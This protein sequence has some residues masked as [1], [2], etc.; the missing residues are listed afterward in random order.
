MHEVH[1]GRPA[2]GCVST[3]LRISALA[4]GLP[5]IKS[6][7]SQ[8]ALKSTTPPQHGTQ[9]TKHEGAT[10]VAV[11]LR[12]AGGA[13]VG[14]DVLY[15]RRKLRAQ[16]GLA[17]PLLGRLDEVQRCHRVAVPRRQALPATQALALGFGSPVSQSTKCW[18]AHAALH[19]VHRPANS[20][21]G[22][23]WPH[24]CDADET[25]A[26]SNFFST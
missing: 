1:Y 5:I 11:T 18:R 25:T 13:H 17:R 26:E 14:V 3:L 22:C 23:H 21:A 4:G 8:H 6:A 12:R 19:T 2:C 20:T 24:M 16:D 15:S 7:H 10:L 9:P